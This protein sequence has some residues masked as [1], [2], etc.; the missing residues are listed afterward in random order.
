MLAVSS[1]V[2]S[3]ILYKIWCTISNNNNLILIYI[4]PVY[5]KYFIKTIRLRPMTLTDFGLPSFKSIK[6][7]EKICLKQKQT[8]VSHYSLLEK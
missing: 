2:S 1:V 6:L 5:I 3:F 8:S 7:R 4:S